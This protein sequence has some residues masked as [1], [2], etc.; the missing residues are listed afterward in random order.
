MVFDYQES[1]YRLNI[2]QSIIENYQNEFLISVW[3]YIL[4]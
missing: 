3:K 2:L 4:H 1:F